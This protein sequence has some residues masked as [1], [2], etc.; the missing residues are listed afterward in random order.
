MR[1]ERS[2]KNEANFPEELSEVSQ[3]IWGKK[4]P[5]MF[6]KSFP[7]SDERSGNL[8]HFTASAKRALKKP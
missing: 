7:K 2:Q 3:A 4:I 1:K 8:R 5:Q 6:P